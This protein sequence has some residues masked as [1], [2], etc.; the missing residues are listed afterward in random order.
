MG[1]NESRHFPCFAIAK[2]PPLNANPTKW[3]QIRHKSDANPTQIPCKSRANLRQREGEE[4]DE[5]EEEEENGF[6]KVL[7]PT[8][9]SL[10]WACLR[11]GRFGG[12]ETCFKAS[13]RLEARGLG[14]LKMFM[15]ACEPQK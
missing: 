8:R 4:E 10:L 2:V 5:G 6:K 9:Y 7:P 12:L 1:G 11:F 3:M 13:T 14:G 15:H